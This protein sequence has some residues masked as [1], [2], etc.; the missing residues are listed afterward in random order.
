MKVLLTGSREHIGTVP[1]WCV[2]ATTSSTSTRFCIVSAPSA[3]GRIRLKRAFAEC[4]SLAPP[5][6]KKT[7]V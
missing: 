7:V 1:S 2:R 5:T 6:F 3:G 4:A